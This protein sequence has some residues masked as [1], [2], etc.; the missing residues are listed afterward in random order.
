VCGNAE[1]AQQAVYSGVSIGEVEHSLFNERF[2]AVS[3]S[4][5]PEVVYRPGTPWGGAL[6]FDTTQGTAHYFGV[7][8]Y[9]RD[10]SDARTSGVS[11]A[12][13]SLPFANVPE[14]ESLANTPDIGN[15]VHDAMWKRRV[16]R[17]GGAGW[18]FEDVRAH[19]VERL[20]GESALLLRETDPARYLALGRAASAAAVERTLQEFRRPGSGCGGALLWLWTDPEMGAGWV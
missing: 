19:Y 9:R 8:A 7:G 13:E 15:R 11:F 12:T 5:V 18:D 20:F 4:V 1:V 14:P 16:P 6:L 3:A 10:L 17:D 2:A